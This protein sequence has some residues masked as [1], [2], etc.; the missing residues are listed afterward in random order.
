MTDRSLYGS[1][2][3][4]FDNHVEIVYLVLY[5][6]EVHARPGPAPAELLLLTLEQGLEMIY[7]SLEDSILPQ[8][9]IDLGFS[10]YGRFRGVPVLSAP[11][12]P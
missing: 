4:L 6:L 1:L 2:L 10:S 3:P 9:G 5:L 7:P 8:Q 12:P 11:A